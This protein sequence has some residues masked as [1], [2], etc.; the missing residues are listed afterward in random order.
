MANCFRCNGLL[1]LD[2][3]PYG[4]L[5]WACYNCGDRLDAVVLANR[6]SPR[7]PIYQAVRDYPIP[8][9]VLLTT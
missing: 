8:C 3:V 2:R 7:T 6:S 4:P 9:K 1:F 5:Q